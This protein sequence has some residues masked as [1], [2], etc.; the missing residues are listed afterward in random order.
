[1]P[2]DQ[3]RLFSARN[4]TR[5]IYV[6]TI[7][8]AVST[9]AVSAA[10]RQTAL[11]CRGSVCVQCFTMCLNGDAPRSKIKEW[12]IQ[13]YSTIIPATETAVPTPRIGRGTIRTPPAAG[14]GAGRQEGLMHAPTGNVPY[15]L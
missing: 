9:A 2:A 14:E 5:H 12:R 7:H 11:A 6:Y 8:T 15:L 10:D 4:V 3:R 1:M 13:A